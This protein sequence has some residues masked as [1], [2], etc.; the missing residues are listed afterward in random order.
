MRGGT[1][2][3]AARSGGNE[4]RQ[5][6]LR[7]GTVETAAH[8]INAGLLG[9]RGFFRRLDVNMREHAFALEL[10]EIEDGVFLARSEHRTRSENSA[11]PGMK[12]GIDPGGKTFRRNRNVLQ[13]R[14]QGSRWM[15]RSPAFGLVRLRD[16][17]QKR[18][19]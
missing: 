11:I 6:R 9:C 5:H 2:E 18:F 15:C 13:E 19:S 12:A 16:R 10:L 17:I 3:E 4:I 7:L 1:G 14:K 8:Q